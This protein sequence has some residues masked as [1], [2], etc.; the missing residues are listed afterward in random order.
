M[1]QRI[2]IQ[3]HVANALQW[4]GTLYRNPADALKEHVSNAID[5]HLKAMAA[6]T[7]HDRCQVTFTLDRRHVTIDYPY[8]MSRAEIE[9]ALERV[10][11]SAKRAGSTRTI[12]RLGIGIF[13]FQ[14]VGRRCTFYTRKTPLAETLCVVLKEGS[15]QASVET[16]LARARLDRPGMRVVIS[17]LKFDPTR[18][19]GPIAPDT[20]RRYLAEKFESYLREGWLTI[21]IR[22]GVGR[23]AVTPARIRLPRLLADLR[24]LA[25]PDAADKKLRL[26]LY[27]DPSGHGRVAIRHHG[28]S[29][30]DD[31]KALAAYGLE[32]SAWAQG[33]VRGV[34]DADFLTP[35]PARSGFEENE[36]WVALL[37]LLDRYLPTIAAELDGHLAAHRAQQVSE[38]SERAVR[39]ARDILDLDEFR[40][41]ALPGGLAKRGRPEPA[42]S[43]QSKATA[44]KRRHAG[45]ASVAPGDRPSARGHRIRYEEVP[46]EDGSRHSR[47]VAGVVQA[48][49]VH[50]DF[51]QAARSSDTRLVYAALMI[52]KESIAFNDRTGSAGDFLERLLDFYFKLNTRKSQRAK[53]RTQPTAAQDSLDLEPPPGR[54][55]QD[56]AG[57]I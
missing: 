10:A 27:F 57:P 42:T 52:G 2:A 14:Q 44:R 34:I 46:F 25:L 8:G 51:Q 39:L 21:E 47:F 22:T 11:D 1:A 15:D 30:V 36:D 41:L 13:S 54:P 23:F 55:R 49:T 50:P 38:I 28:V 3:L 43:R 31:L 32:T 4:L 16:A 56:A 18:S 53:R 19:R 24:E 45:E 40:D 7:A 37:D 48:N 33:S 29:I 17:E 9:S 26:D 12:G 35:L 6:G 20:L 5:E